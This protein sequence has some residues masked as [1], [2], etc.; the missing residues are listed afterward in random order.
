M[1]LGLHAQIGLDVSFE[2]PAECLVICVFDGFHI[3]VGATQ[4]NI[5]ENGLFCAW[6]IHGLEQEEY[7]LCQWAADD[8]RE[9]IFER[10]TDFTLN[11]IDEVLLEAI[12]VDF[13]DDGNLKGVFVGQGL[14][15]EFLVGS[16]SLH[17]FLESFSVC[18]TVIWDVLCRTVSHGWRGR[19]GVLLLRSS[20]TLLW[21]VLLRGWCTISTLG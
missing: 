10:P 20:V 15:E 6:S 1:A 12:L 14:D 7:I 13:L 8:C 19:L 21:W 9:S 11:L 3:C 18:D 2:N 16:E 5:I 4:E 17:S